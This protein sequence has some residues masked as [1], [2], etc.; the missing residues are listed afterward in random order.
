MKI[1]FTAL[2]AAASLFADGPGV[3]LS[4]YSDKDFA[5]TA[6]PSAAHWKSVEP[7]I[8]ENNARGV[9]TP[10]HRTEI[11][12]RWT[13]DNV[14]FL[15]VCPYET[16][17]LKPNPVRDKETNKLWEWDVAEVFV[18][19]DFENFAG[20]YRCLDCGW[21]DSELLQ[22]A[23]CLHC[24]YRFPAA[25]AIGA[26][27]AV[28]APAST[29]VLFHMLDYSTGEAAKRPPGS[30]QYPGMPEWQSARSKRLRR[31]RARRE[32]AA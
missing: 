27:V 30:R 6:D 15:F 3:I 13:R 8:A 16:L 18:G 29:E 26:N 25:E 1:I 32:L 11:R 14:Y 22:I 23:Q 10:N 17:H 24:R 7:V 2:I 31:Y 19:A 28:Y 4:R 5:L 12:S 21:S 20:P 9:P